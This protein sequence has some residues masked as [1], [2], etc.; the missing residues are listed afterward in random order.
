MELTVSISTVIT[1]CF[2]FLGVYV[3]MPFALIGRDFLILKFI[4]RYIMNEG[5]WSILRIVNTDKAIHNYQFAGK[6]SQMSI[7]GMG[8]RYT[9]DGKEVTESEYLQFERGLQMHLN[10]INQLEPKILLRTNFIVWADK[11][12]KLESGLMKQIER[13][14]KR[15][16]ERQ[17][18]TLKE[19]DNK[20]P[21]Q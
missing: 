4:E 16:Y 17:I 13:F 14:S 11:Y 8:Q 18:R 19:Q 10:R 7:V 15:V 9:I 21:Q 5:F 12:F 2:G 3:L 6:K 20:G 1:A